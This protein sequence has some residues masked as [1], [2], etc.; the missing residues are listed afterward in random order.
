MGCLEF[1]VEELVVQDVFREF[2]IENLMGMTYIGCSLA[3]QLEN[4]I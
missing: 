3:Y 4:V 1:D 2:I